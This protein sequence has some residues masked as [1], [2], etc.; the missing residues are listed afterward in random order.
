V[1]GISARFLGQ[2]H[3]V[4]QPREP[5]AHHNKPTSAGWI[6][7]VTGPPY[8][9]RTQGADEGPSAVLSMA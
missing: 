9:S 4:P 1:S 2:V 6:V 5:V 3:E 7:Q 8:V